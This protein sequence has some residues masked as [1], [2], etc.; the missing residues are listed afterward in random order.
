M[1]SQSDDPLI[2]RP[3]PVAQDATIKSF[4]SR[5]TISS[6]NTQLISKKTSTY[7]IEQIQSL[8]DTSIDKI[9]GRDEL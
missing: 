8:L 6:E 3:R 4:F 7:R 5:G 2:S 9:P 1:A